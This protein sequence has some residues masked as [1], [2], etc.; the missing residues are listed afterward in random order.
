MRCHRTIL[1]ILK[2]WRQLGVTVK[3]SDEGEYWQ[4]RSETKLR[5]ILS[6]YDG[7]MA[8]VA[9]A[10]KDAADETSTG[11]SVES[12]ILARKDF[13]KLEAEGWREFGRQLPQLPHWN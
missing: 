13:E 12:P 5:D 9:G 1:S 6:R 7:L 10:F 2:F 8:V 11:Y 3:V 4:T